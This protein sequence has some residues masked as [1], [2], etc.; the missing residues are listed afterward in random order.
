LPSCF[1]Q[2]R[3]HVGPH[4][5]QVGEELELPFQ[6][7][8]VEHHLAQLQ[9]APAIIFLHGH[10]DDSVFQHAAVDAFIDVK[11]LL[12]LVNGV[13]LDAGNESG[14]LF[15]KQ[16]EGFIIVVSL[17]E[18]VNSVVIRFQFPQQQVIVRGSG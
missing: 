2:G 12:H 8:V 17:V 10:L 3:Y 6:H 13:L 4:L 5:E 16:L 9:L 1:I 7:P 14:S 15:T 11:F 18:D